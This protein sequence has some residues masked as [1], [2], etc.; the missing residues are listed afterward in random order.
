MLNP[1]M[2]WDGLAATRVADPSVYPA[3][4]RHHLQKYASNDL[5][6]LWLICVAS[7]RFVLKAHQCHL[8]AIF[9]NNVAVRSLTRIVNTSGVDSSNLYVSDP[10]ENTLCGRNAICVSKGHIAI[11]KCPPN[12][13]GNPLDD[14]KGCFRRKSTGHH[15]RYPCIDVNKSNLR[16]QSVFQPNA[17]TTRTASAPRHAPTTSASVCI[18]KRTNRLCFKGFVYVCLTNRSGKFQI[19]VC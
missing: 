14:I 13:I 1:N 18:T 15:A 9:F 11:C 4:T 5:S 17:F 2:L 16:I 7:C 12:Y 6:I 10:C 8:L 3:K 19:L